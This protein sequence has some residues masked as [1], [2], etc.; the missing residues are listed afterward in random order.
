VNLEPSGALPQGG[1]VL[2]LGR[3]GNRLQ[4]LAADTT[5]DGLG[6]EP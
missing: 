2:V 6:S 4:V 3:D 1:S 5:S